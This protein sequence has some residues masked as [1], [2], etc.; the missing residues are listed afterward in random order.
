MDC[1]KP[2]HVCNIKVNIDIMYKDNIAAHIHGEEWK[3]ILILEIVDL[4]FLESVT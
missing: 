1:C 4:I 2:P 3:I